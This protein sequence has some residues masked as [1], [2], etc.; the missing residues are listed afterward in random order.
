[1][2]ADSVPPE[3][4]ILSFS[5]ENLMDSVSTDRVLFTWSYPCV[6]TIDLIISLVTPGETKKRWDFS[7][8]I[9]DPANIQTAQQ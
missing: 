3:K 1:M 5:S 4:M 7:Q 2:S 6:F 8:R 9:S